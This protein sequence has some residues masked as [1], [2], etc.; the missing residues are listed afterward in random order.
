MFVIGIICY[1]R[2][3]DTW[4]ALS[5][6]HLDLDSFKSIF[7][8]EIRTTKR[9]HSFSSEESALEVPRKY[10]HCTFECTPKRLAL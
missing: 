10:L 2:F 3:L 9:M 1:I 4:P 8:K 6:F 5:F 7:Y